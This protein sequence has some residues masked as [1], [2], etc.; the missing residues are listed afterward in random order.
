MSIVR[1]A[2]ENHLKMNPLM[3]IRQLLSAA[4][5][6]K[7]SREMPS[8]ALDDDVRRWEAGENNHVMYLYDF[9]KLTSCT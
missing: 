1:I 6:K 9:L 5:Y 7:H 2:V 4:Y 3:T 8:G